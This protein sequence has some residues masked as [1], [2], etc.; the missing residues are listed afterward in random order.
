MEEVN[1]TAWVRRGAGVRDF[2]M[3]DCIET[4]SRGLYLRI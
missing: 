3:E 2:V 1:L 4:C